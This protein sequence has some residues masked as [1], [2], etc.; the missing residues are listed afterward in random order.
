[1][2]R[3]SDDEADVMTGIPIWRNGCAGRANA[4]RELELEVKADPAREAR[5]SRLSMP[6]DY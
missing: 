1:M 6:L 5:K 4:A 2:E 3:C